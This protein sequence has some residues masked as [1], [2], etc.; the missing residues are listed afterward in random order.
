MS[1]I[2]VFE[3]LLGY[4]SAPSSLLG[5]ISCTGGLSGK[6]SVP[7]NYDPYTGEYEVAS[8]VF[9]AKILPTANKLLNQDVLIKKVPYFETSNAQNGLTVYIGGEES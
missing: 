9:N 1:S 6:L 4:I 3:S 2:K 8:D 7:T 5:E